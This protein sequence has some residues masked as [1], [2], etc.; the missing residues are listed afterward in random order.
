MRNLVLR[1]PILQLR[2]NF[3]LKRTFHLRVQKA[4]A[5]AIS[6]WIKRRRLVPRRHSFLVLLR[7]EDIVETDRDSKGAFW[8]QPPVLP[9]K[10]PIQML[11]PEKPGFASETVENVEIFVTILYIQEAN[12]LQGYARRRRRR[13]RIIII[14]RRPL[15]ISRSSNLS[16]PTAE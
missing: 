3:F 11:K 7:E 14:N 16:G 2:P 15:I 10:H 12:R 4:D 9:G 5:S 1:E 8:R 6:H 13:R